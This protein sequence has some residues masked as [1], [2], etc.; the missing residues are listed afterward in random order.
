MK[1]LIL[2]FI[3]VIFLTGCNYM[4]LNDLAIASSIG[5]DYDN[6]KKEFDITAQIMNVKSGDSGSTDE[7]TIIY[8]ASGKTM[9][10]AISNFSIRYP[11][12]VYLGHLEMC[13]LGKDAVERKLNNIFDYFIRDSEAKSS[14][15]VLIAKDRKAKEILNPKNEKS[16]NFPTEDLKSV[17]I[18]GT[19]KTGT[20][21]K[22]T[23]EEFLSLTIQK[24]IDP[25]IPTV[26]IKT[27]DKNTSSNTVI[28]G[29][30]V[31]KKNMKEELSKNGSIGFNTIKEN[32][33][34]TTIDVKYKN[35]YISF[36]I[37]NPKS[38]IKT[39]FKDKPVFNIDINIESKVSEIDERI[40][41]NDE[42]VKKYFEKRINNTIKKYVT[43]LLIYN[44]NNNVDILGLSNLIYKNYPKKYKYIKNKNIYEIGRINIKVN[45][46]MYVHGNINEGA[47]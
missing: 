45:N 42:K 8:E 40:N 39:S 18:D 43:E 44:K 25:A 1:K 15:Y 23:L 9:S 13:V 36:V 14:C 2:L 35:D 37:S 29:I 19:N 46:E 16:E 26:D 11:R 28:N 24:G 27:N 22:I 17:L 20:I 12:N 38:K 34:N 5:V 7:A 21:N 4:E 6:N 33:S 31:V 41:L 10:E 30:T 3:P 47:L 32:Y